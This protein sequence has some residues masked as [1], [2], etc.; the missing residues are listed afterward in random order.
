MSEETTASAEQPKVEMTREQAIEFVLAKQNFMF[1]ESDRAER[2]AVAKRKGI[3]LN[4][5]IDYTLEELKLKVPL[6]RDRL[7]YDWKNEDKCTSGVLAKDKNGLLSMPKPKGKRKPHMTLHQQAIK[8][9]SLRIF[10]ALFEEKA[11]RLKAVCKKEQ[12]EYIGVPESSIPE[13]GARAARMAVQEVNESKR[14]RRA[15]ARRRQDFSR[16]VNAGTF[17]N[18]RPSERNYV[19]HGGQY[20]GN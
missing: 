8:S 6:K 3:E 7:N 17:G 11:E 10:R 16:K 9:A 2:T 13:L 4:P 1:N 5:S 14:R 20:D 15:K 12:F 19:E 18:A